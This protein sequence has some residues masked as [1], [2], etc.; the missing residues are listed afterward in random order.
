MEVDIDPFS[1]PELTNNS[2]GQSVATPPL[3]KED[4]DEWL[5]DLERSDNQEPD[6]SQDSAGIDETMKLDESPDP[7]FKEDPEMQG[8]S[9]HEFVNQMFNT[10]QEVIP[11]STTSDRIAEGTRE[12]ARSSLIV[13]LKVKPNIPLE[14]QRESQKNNKSPPVVRHCENCKKE[15]LRARV[16]WYK[17]CF[18]CDPLDKSRCK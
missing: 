11:N 16:F 15:L 10:Q 4:M 12:V 8:L 5:D 14:K 13:T 6:L 3:T 18:Q 1:F 2:V 17:Q 9:N 7:V